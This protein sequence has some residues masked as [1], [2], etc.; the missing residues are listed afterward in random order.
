MHPDII[1]TIAAERSKS[2]REQAAAYR[3]SGQIRRSRPTQRH[4]PF[5]RLARAGARLR[6]RVA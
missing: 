3:L 2:V 5:L 4:R 6:L 1:Q